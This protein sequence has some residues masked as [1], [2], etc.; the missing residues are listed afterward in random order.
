[1]S[2]DPPLPAGDRLPFDEVQAR[3]L[4]LADLVMRLLVSR[5][6]SGTLRTTRVTT[7]TNLL[8]AAVAVCAI[9]LGF[10]VALRVVQGAPWMWLLAEGALVPLAVGCADLAVYGI[11]QRALQ[12]SRRPS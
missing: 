6:E 12:A 2:V 8:A 5:P 9:A 7:V 3:L 1:M 10:V 4:P 11:R